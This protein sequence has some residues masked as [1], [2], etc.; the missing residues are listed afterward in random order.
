MEKYILSKEK[1]L[2]VQEIQD[3]FV[4]LINQKN[5]FDIDELNLY[6][7][8][9]NLGNFELRLTSIKILSGISKNNLLRNLYEYYYINYI[10]SGK[11]TKYKN[12]LIEDIFE[13]IKSMIKINKFDI[14]NYMNFRDNMR[15]NYK[16]LNK[17][18]KQNE[19]LYIE[20]NLVTIIQNEQKEFMDKHYIEKMVN[21]IEINEEEI[22][23]IYSITY[24]NIIERL[25]GLFSLKKEINANY[26]HKFLLDLIQKL[27]KNG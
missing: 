17:L 6:L 18:L 15:R 8:S 20:N 5:D 24:K 16:Q 26:K 19:N 27:Q 4:N 22:E 12:N 13:K 14:K 7:Q 3:N 11:F 1:E 2:I 9:S 21:S 10:Q 23:N 25:K